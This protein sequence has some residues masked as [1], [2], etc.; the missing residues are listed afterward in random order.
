MQRI[1]ITTSH[2]RGDEPDMIRTILNHGWERVHLRH[3]DA[4][5]RDIRR[6]IEAV[7]QKYHN[8]LRIHGHFTLINEFNLGGL[9]LNKRCPLPPQHY[10]GPLS[11]SCHSLAEVAKA[12]DM[13]YVTLSPIFDSISKSGYFSTFSS[14]DLLNL[15]KTAPV[16]VIALGGITPDNVGTLAQYGFAGFATL[17]YLMEARDVEELNWRLA[18]FDGAM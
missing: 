3:P 10:R 1:A 8:R 15:K 16:P 12:S 9:H 7:P 17:G 13:E 4:S 18:Q 6:I 14:S 5:L 11:R 2:I